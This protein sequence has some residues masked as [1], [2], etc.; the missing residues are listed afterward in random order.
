MN[1]HEYTWRRRCPPII[2]LSGR[3][4]P[5]SSRP[6]DAV[7]ARSSICS[8]RPSTMSLLITRPPIGSRAGER[9]ASARRGARRRGPGAAH[10]EP[11]VQKAEEIGGAV[12]I[13][14]GNCA[15]RPLTS[16]R[17]GRRPHHP[18]WVKLEEL[19]GRL[20]VD[21]LLT[22]LVGRPGHLIISD[23]RRPR[24]QY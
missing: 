19:G 8:A 4:W 9:G 1:T 14:S 15:T 5:V 24:W 22:L 20:V 2:L 13:S 11:A 10:G 18:V 23:D 12:I 3:V 6:H 17:T 7:P 21:C 16:A